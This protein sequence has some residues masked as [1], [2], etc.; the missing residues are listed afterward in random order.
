MINDYKLPSV[1]DERQ[2]VRITGE[3]RE[4]IDEPIGVDLKDL[5]PVLF[6]AQ[7]WLRR[8]LKGP[9]LV[10]DRPDEIPAVRRQRD[11]PLPC[12]AD[13]ANMLAG[14]RIPHV[15]VA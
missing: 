15:G 2:I 4:A 12:R 3:V 9:V 5:E 7:P 13:V 10:F 1:L 14:R 8:I 6:K 11:T